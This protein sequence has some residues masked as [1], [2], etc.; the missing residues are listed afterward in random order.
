MPN[1]PDKSLDG[2]NIVP[3]MHPI[4]ERAN[5]R[6]AELKTAREQV[7]QQLMAIENQIFALTDLLN[8]KTDAPDTPGV[9]DTP[10][11]TI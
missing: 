2:G 8:P 9:P 5:A 7:R 1:K 3:Q 11:G 4:E 6:L 10:P